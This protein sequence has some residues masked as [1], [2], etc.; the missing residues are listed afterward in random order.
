MGVVKWALHCRYDQM[1][2]LLCGYG[3]TCNALWVCSY[4]QCIVVMDICALHCVY[5]QMGIALWIWSDG[6]CIL[7][8]ITWESTMTV[9]VLYICLLF[10]CVC[11]G[12][13][14]LQVNDRVS[15]VPNT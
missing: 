5:G 11:T 3:Q 10:Q 8:V 14:R 13:L 9:F 2:I 1:N 7:G 6:H 12:L 15:A 4:V